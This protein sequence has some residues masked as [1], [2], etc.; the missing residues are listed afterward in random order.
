MNCSQCGAE[1][2]SGAAFCSQ[3]GAQLDGVAADRHLGP[4]RVSSGDSRR[5]NT[6]EQDLWTGSYSPKAMIGSFIG[7]ALLTIAGMIG[8]SFAG[9]VG[10]IAVAIGAAIVFGYLGLLL[11][12]RRL[13]TSYRLT[14][15]RLL[16]DLG[17][18]NRRS[19]HLLVVNIDD[20][21][22]QQ[23]LFDRM[24]NLGTIRLKVKD[25]STPE[26]LMLGIE[27]PRHVADL[28]DQARRTERNRRGLYTM[29]A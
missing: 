28:I 3:C 5:D 10:W 16:R 24:F 2:P 29:D 1:A 6:P 17:I 8:A 13:G 18:L 14:T 19:D 25:D 20:V 15:Q 21:T 4:A 23:P 9:P 26:L 7:A 12:Y 27:N 11:A 22:V